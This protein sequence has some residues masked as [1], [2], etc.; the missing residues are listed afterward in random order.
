MAAL[1][2]GNVVLGGLVG[3]SFAV[4]ARYVAPSSV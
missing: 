4:M 2:T 1:T 3:F